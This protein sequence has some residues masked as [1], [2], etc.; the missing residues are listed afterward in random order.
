MLFIT[1][2]QNNEDKEK[3]CKLCN[4]KLIS[5]SLS[6]SASELD[7]ETK[8]FKNYIGLCQFTIH[9]NKGIIES[10]TNVTNVSDVEALQIMARTVTNFIYRCGIEDCYFNIKNN[11]SKLSSLLNFKN[12]NDDY[13]YM[14]LKS[15]YES[16]CK[17]NNSNK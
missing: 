3:L 6:Y 14:N 5:D 13:S 4:V 11:D 17:Y 15:Y 16:P 12:Y 1:P 9:D 7:D 8:E 2:I 10:L